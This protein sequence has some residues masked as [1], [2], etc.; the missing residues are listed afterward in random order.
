MTYRIGQGIDFHRLVNGRKLWLGGIN[1]PS[2]K[3][4]EAHSDGDALLHAI[5]DALLGAAGLFDIGHY[6]PDNDPEYLDIDSKL[7]LEKTIKLIKKEGYNVENID[8]T[9]CLEKPKVSKYIS[10]MRKTIASVVDISSESVSVK[11]TSTEKMGMTGSEEG[12]FA[13]ASVLLIKKS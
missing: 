2:E 4:C 7:L 3:G 9:I 6:F 12:L 1:I 13:I 5:C 8:S 10:E 11:A